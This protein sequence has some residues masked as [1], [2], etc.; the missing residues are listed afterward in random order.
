MVKKKTK[1]IIESEENPKVEHAYVKFPG[2]EA[3]PV[4]LSKTE[5]TTEYDYREINKLWEEAGRKKYAAIHTHSYDSDR[6]K[7]FRLRDDDP[8]PS[9]RDMIHFLS[10]DEAKSM[11]IGHQNNKSGNLDGYVVFRKTKKTPKSS[12]SP[13][14]DPEATMK[15]F[16]LVERITHSLNSFMHRW[17]HR[18]EH[19]SNPAYRKLIRR[20]KEYDAATQT[21]F[22]FDRPDILHANL[23]KFAEQYHLQ[24]K[25]VPEKGKTVNSTR[26]RFL[27]KSAMHLIGIGT[28]VFLGIISILGASVLTGN[29]VN[30]ETGMQ[31]GFAFLIGL[32]GLV[33]GILGGTWLIRIKRK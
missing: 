15:E 32:I 19:P 2:K 24:Y 10:D 23:Y 9:P 6:Q 14:Y 13:V 28:G 12:N 31:T 21:A 22:Y 11:V 27:E 16:T 26:T 5:K 8:L 3:V 29:S 1:E 20:T 33:L 18:D 17:V 7:K 30:N 4:G 25:F